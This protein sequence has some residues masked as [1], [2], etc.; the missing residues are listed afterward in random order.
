[1]IN[2]LIK[3]RSGEGEL[4]NYTLVWASKIGDNN[5]GFHERLVFSDPPL[6]LN[7]PNN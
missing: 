4:R 1:M 3:I 7:N 5:S 2:E 6:D